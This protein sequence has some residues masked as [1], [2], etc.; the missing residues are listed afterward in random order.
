MEISVLLLGQSETLANL[1]LL[2]GRVAIGVC[3]MIHAL[4]KL[5]LVGTGNMQGF[6]AWLEDLGV[7]LAP[8]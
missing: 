8:V 7:P 2:I 1:A 3:F 4:G 6:V 5:G